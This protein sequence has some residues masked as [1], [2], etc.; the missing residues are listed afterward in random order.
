[1]SP[2]VSFAGFF[3][4]VGGIIFVGWWKEK[5]RTEVLQAFAASLKFSFSPDSNDSLPALQDRF[6]L[7]SQGHARKMS[8]VMRGSANGI[9]V[10]LFDYRY[11]TGSGK[12][13]STWNQ[14]VILFQSGLLQLPAFTLRPESVFHR[15]KQ[16]FGYPDIDF[17]THPEFSKQYLLQ[18]AD[19]NGVR[20]L[21]SDALLAHFAQ[22]KGVSAEGIGDQL[23]YCRVSKRVPPEALKVFMQE[24]FG[25]FALVKTAG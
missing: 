11:T 22:S 9:D 14:T 1:M 23:L 19:G 25:V 10:T 17:D 18:G 4:I 5:K 7:F 21:F 20:A 6:H 15:I 13:S 8:N 24:G 2:I 3:A 12:S 16:A